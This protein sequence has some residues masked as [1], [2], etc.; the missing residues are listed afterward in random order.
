MVGATVGAAVGGVV[1]GLLASLLAAFVIYRRQRALK[2]RG[3][4]REPTPFIST[5]HDSRYDPLSSQSPPADRQA[6]SLQQYHSTES[7]QRSLRSP[8]STTTLPREY[9]I[10]PFQPDGPSH[11]MARS[12]ATGSDA[13]APTG[14]PWNDAQGTHVR[15]V[16][17]SASVS[18]RQEG[19][20]QVYVIHHDSGRAPVSVITQR[21]TEVVE[22]PPGYTSEYLSMGAA[23]SQ[24]AGDAHAQRR[25]G[26]TTPGSR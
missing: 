15:S 13:T 3:H 4:E 10:E 6:F 1:L 14:P 26:M 24:N 20:S 9:D 8:A 21:G 12:S 11:L 7:K 25:N 18:N 5:S 23:V 17:G 22:L 19:G 2:Q 16:S